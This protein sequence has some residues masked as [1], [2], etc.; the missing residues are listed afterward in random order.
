[1]PENPSGSRLHRGENR[2]DLSEEDRHSTQD[3]AGLS[4]GTA[5]DEHHRGLA[6]PGSRRPRSI[7]S[8]ADLARH[9]ARGGRT[10]G[11][12]I[13]WRRTF[14]AVGGRVR[15]S[16]P[17][18]NRNV[19]IPVVPNALSS[20]LRWRLSIHVRENCAAGNEHLVIAVWR[21]KEAYS[22]YEPPCG[23]TSHRTRA[24]S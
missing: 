13:N 3:Q 7:D 23:C 10:Q 6:V 15:Y 18:L 19:H 16:K 22:K 12:S 20:R 2:K 24:Q 14:V 1:M 8:R 5:P 21:Q 11:L 17:E 9:E 4:G